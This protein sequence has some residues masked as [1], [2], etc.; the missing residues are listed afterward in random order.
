MHIVMYPTLFLSNVRCRERKLKSQNQLSFKQI[1]ELFFFFHALM[2]MAEKSNQQTFLQV[3][4]SRSLNFDPK[5]VL[6]TLHTS[7]ARSI[8]KLKL[9]IPHQ[10]F[11]IPVNIDFCQKFSVF[12]C[13]GIQVGPISLKSQI[14]YTYLILK[15]YRLK[16]CKTAITLLTLKK[17]SH[18]RT[19][20]THFRMHFARTFATHP[21][22]KT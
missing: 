18:T 17:G 10:Q 2:I 22:F 15:R 8:L 21:L 16:V 20:H 1:E 5:V 14:Y 11:R 7:H 4:I 6:C 3:K 19:S 9:Q 12:F 13:M